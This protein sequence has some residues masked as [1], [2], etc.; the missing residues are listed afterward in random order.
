V[1]IIIERA[2]AGDAGELTTVQ[3]AAYLSEGR[4]YR[5]LEI[6]PLTET[7]DEVRAVLAGD[8]VVLVARHGHRL[9]GSVRGRVTDRVG[10]IGRLA[11][12]PDMQGRGIGRRLIAAVERELAGRVDGFELFTGA[13]S[14]ENVRLYE[15]CGYAVVAH[16]STPR[17]P[18]LVFLARKTG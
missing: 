9:V 13:D 8:T 11:V 5:D 15:S 16:R 6:P 3:R 10:E 14:V 2:V 12:A 1:E 4:R 17:G 18:G 7:V